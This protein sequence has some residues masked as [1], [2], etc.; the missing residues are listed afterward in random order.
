MP[1][2]SN[3]APHGLERAFGVVRSSG[4]WSGY[5]ISE[6]VATDDGVRWARWAARYLRG[7]E[8]D[9]ACVV[10]EHV[11]FAR[12]EAPRRPAAGG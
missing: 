8:G 9:A 1:Q 5:R 10:L 2:A 6:I 11:N 12:F 4:K 7:A 3:A